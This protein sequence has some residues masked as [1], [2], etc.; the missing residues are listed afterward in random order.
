MDLPQLGLRRLLAE[1]KIGHA[2]SH[3][4]SYCDSMSGEI[5]SR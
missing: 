4:G 1:V 3:K 5:S 2:E